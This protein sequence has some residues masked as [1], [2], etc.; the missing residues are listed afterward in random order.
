MEI[1]PHERA[2]KVKALARELGFEL[3]GIARAE[4]SAHGEALRAWLAA[5]MHGAMKYME[6]GVEERVDVR[7]KLP[8]A[9]SIVCVGLAYWQKSEATSQKSEGMGKIAR[10]AWG[11]DYHKVLEGKLRRMEKVVRGELGGGGEVIQL[12]SYVDT[13][14]LL[15]REWAAKAGLGWVGK[16]TLLIHPRHGSWFVLG[17]MVMSVELEPDSPMTDHCGTCTRCIDACPTRAITPHCVDSRLCISY[18]TLENRGE[19]PEG[20]KGAMKAA[21]YVIGCDICQEACPFNGEGRVLEMREP[22]FAA[23]TPAPAVPLAEVLAW[24]EQE[25]DILTRGRAG[26]R[27]KFE[28]WKRN[29][30]V[31]GGEKHGV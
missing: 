17:E 31:L 30:R 2:A 21:G 5:G 3:V 4:P 8:W 10:Y 6:K 14:P 19:I 26:R 1:T 15:E 18:Q 24:Q 27:A 20:M 29:A 7:K 25:W 12:R 23:R 13:G 9:R 28:M 11:R 22:D 16:N